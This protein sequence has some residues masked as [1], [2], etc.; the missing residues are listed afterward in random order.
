MGMKFSTPVG[1]LSA[2]IWL[3]AGSVLWSEAAEPG[4]TLG[5][6]VAIDVL[7]HPD[8]TMLAAAAQA[9]AELRGDYPAGFALDKLHTP[10]ISMIQRFVRRDDL[11]RIE[12]ELDK[13]FA[14]VAPTSLEL[15]AI[16]YYSLP[17]GELGLAGIVVAPTKELRGLQDKIIAAVEPFAV[18]GTVAAFVPSADGAAI[19]PS[20]VEYVNTYV[21]ERSGKNF[22]PHVTVGL[23]TAPFVKRMIATPFPKFAFTIKGASVYHLGNYGTA[24]VELWSPAGQGTA[25]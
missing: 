20:I 4:N 11:E 9:N 15:Q 13:V 5:E 1:A 2:A 22:N 25:K 18:K 17:V 12:G 24:A 14:E 3:A 10:H 19:A 23:G 21:P 16:G 6:I 7:L 8:A